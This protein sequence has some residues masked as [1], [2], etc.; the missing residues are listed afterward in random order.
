MIRNS[1]AFDVLP[2]EASEWKR[3]REI[4]LRSLA[5]SPAAF[6]SRLETERLHPD[7]VWRERAT[8]SSSR[9][10]WSARAGVSWVGLTGVV[11][12]EVARIELISMWVDPA[13]R[14]RGVARALIAAV[15]GWQRRRRGS[16][17]YLWVT[18]DNAPAERCY[19][20]AGFRLTG[21]RLQVTPDPSG[22]RVEMCL[23]I[24]GPH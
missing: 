8:P 6:A 14:R 10:M 1:T 2:V 19:E 11:R 22:D 7:S 24:A 12:T 23:E 9:R 15:V 17:I 20:Q 5:D 13:W 3:L 18:P 4:R 16:E 21:T